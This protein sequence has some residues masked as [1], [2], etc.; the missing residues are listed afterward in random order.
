MSI[1]TLGRYGVVLFLAAL[2]SGCSS[3]IGEC[4]LVRS[5]C[6]Y[7]GKYEQGEEDYAEAEAK[8]LNKQSTDRLRR[9]S[10]D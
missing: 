4:G 7:E 5:S 6:M 2:S 9:S 8:R 10:G 3:I 1:H